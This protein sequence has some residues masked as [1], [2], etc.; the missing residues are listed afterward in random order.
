MNKSRVTTSIRLYLT[1]QTFA[2]IATGEQLIPHALTGEPGAGYTS[3]EF[4]GQLDKEFTDHHTYLHFTI[5]RLSE[6][7]R[8]LLLVYHHCCCKQL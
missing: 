1:V 6:C 2:G 4:T 5:R 3:Q 8:C 7:Q